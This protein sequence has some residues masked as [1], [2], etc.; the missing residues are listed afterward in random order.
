MNNIHLHSQKRSGLLKDDINKEH[1]LEYRKSLPYDAMGDYN[2]VGSILPSEIFGGHD[3]EEKP[4]PDEPVSRLDELLDILQ[5][6]KW[7]CQAEYNY[8]RTFGG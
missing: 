5:K 2:V 8:Y 3:L 6:N 7:I 4:L 1:E